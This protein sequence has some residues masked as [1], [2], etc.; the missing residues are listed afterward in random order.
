MNSENEPLTTRF[1]VLP[2]I[3]GMLLALALP[4]F[5][6]SFFIWVALVPL[7][8]FVSKSEIS[9]RRAFQ[10]GFM[11]GVVY[12]S[13]VVYPL[14]S[15]QAWW[16]LNTQGIVYENKILLLFWILYIG[17]FVGSMLFGVCAR[18]FKKIH[19]EGFI[20][21]FI[22]SIVWVFLEY[23]RAKILFGFTWG[24]LGYSLHD[25]LPLMQMV[26]FGGIY[27]ASF[28]V[29]LINILLHYTLYQ[30]HKDIKGVEGHSKAMLYIRSLGNHWYL[31]GAMGIV[32]VLFLGGNFFLNIPKGE[33]QTH[34]S[35]AVIQPG[36]G[37]AIEGHEEE[38]FQMVE[39]SLVNKP[40]IVVI[41]ESAFSSII[42]DEDTME[43]AQP[44]S[45][46][47][48]MRPQVNNYYTKL[49]NLSKAYPTVSLVVGVKTKRGV[50]DYNSMVSIE[51]GEVT[52]MYH[53]RILFPFSERTTSWLPFKNP[54]P[55]TPG[56]KHG[57][58]VVQGEHVGALICSESLFSQLAK[59]EDAQFIIAVGN[60]GVFEDSRVAL[61][62]HII[63]KFVAV[64]TGKY[65]VR[66]MKTGVSSIIK[67][68]GDVVV[69]SDGGKKG[70]IFGEVV[71][72]EE[73]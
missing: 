4:W 53:K 39:Q 62:N 44:S 69:K 5:D 71:L 37:E 59:D 6:L 9:P 24:H 41:P 73:F 8:L 56:E 13:S 48:M 29:V 2:I 66:A 43:V 17:V 19:Q 63:A 42:I 60:D 21:I 26:R 27:T 40:A 67:P 30:S 47:G 22:L 12:F 3:S 14:F 64:E 35:V 51:G 72:E 20:S 65:V 52:S 54:K 49:K 31:Y 34:L 28:F 10:G 18:I 70:I 1:F 38:I 58:L 55:L 68:T 7:F 36:I 33:S 45:P 32:A 61:Y 23:I 15:L 57:G 25:S 11:T 46:M 16:W 50:S